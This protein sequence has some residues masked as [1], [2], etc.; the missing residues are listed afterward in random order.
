MNAHPCDRRRW[1]GRRPLFTGLALALGTAWL[2]S[3]GQSP[4]TNV[5]PALVPPPAP[6]TTYVGSNLPRPPW[7][8]AEVSETPDWAAA[9]PTA[10]PFLT[11]GLGTSTL[12]SPAIPSIFSAAPPDHSRGF[13]AGPFDFRPRLSYEVVYGDGLT[14][15]PTRDQATWLQTISPG[16]QTLWGDHWTLD[17]TPSVR[18]YSADNYDNTVNHSLTLG[19]WAVW[20]DWNYHLNHNTAITSDPLVETGVQTDQTSHSSSIGATWDRGAAGS[21]D[22]SLSQ[23]VRLTQA[24]A[25]SY[26]WTSDNWYNRPWNEKASIGVGLSVGYDLMDPGVEMLNQRLNVRLRGGLGAKVTYEIGAGGE[27]RHFY[28]AESSPKLSP[29]VNGSL[30]YQVLERTALTMGFSH[31]IRPSYFNDT[32]TENSTFQGTLTQIL[33][34]MWSL[35]ASGGYRITSYQ[36]TTSPDQRQRE[37]NTAFGRFSVNAKLLD[38]LNASLYYAYRANTSDRNDFAF[39]SNQI[40]LSLTWSL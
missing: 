24:F 8:P 30:T 39:D 19:G 2:R 4:T 37:D 31:D 6:T 27:W 35:S 25:D 16:L 33:S 5:P 20:R 23:N 40:G 15:G 22:F 12:G 11:P 9:T 29:L 18:I 21:F 13:R 28:G 36:S 32:Y 1:R 14:S 10:P 7:L 38:Q 3:H 26:S 17:Y 34:P